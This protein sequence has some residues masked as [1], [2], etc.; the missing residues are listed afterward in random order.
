M[1]EHRHLIIRAEVTNPPKDPDYIKTWL[2]K[3]VKLINMKLLD[4]GDQSN[5]VV[6]YCNKLGNRGLTGAALI[7]TSHILFHSWDEGTPVIQLDVYS[8]SHLCAATVIDHFKVFNPTEYQYIILDRKDLISV[9]KNNDWEA[10]V[11]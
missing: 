5:P 9:E 11:L 8:C 1:I 10:L 7:E 6:T 3:L 2:I 4:V